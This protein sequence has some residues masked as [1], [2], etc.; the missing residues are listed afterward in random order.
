MWGEIDEQKYEIGPEMHSQ[1]NWQDH[2]ALLARA[3]L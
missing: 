2:L 1:I 3:L